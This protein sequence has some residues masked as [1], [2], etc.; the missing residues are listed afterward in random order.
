MLGRIKNILHYAIV[1]HIC[2]RCK[3]V[4]HRSYLG[5]NIEAHLETLVLTNIRKVIRFV[6]DDTLKDFHVEQRER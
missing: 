6:F 5:Q 4:E 1:A 2:M 3:R